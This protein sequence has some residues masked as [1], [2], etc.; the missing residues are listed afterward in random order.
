LSSAIGWHYVYSIYRED[1]PVISPSSVYRHYYSTLASLL[2]L[3]LNPPTAMNH[4]TRAI[5][6]QW[7]SKMHITRRHLHR[8][9]RAIQ[10]ASAHTQRIHGISRV[11][12]CRRL[13]RRPNNAR[14]NSVNT[15]TIWCLLLRKTAGESYDGAL[16]GGVVEKHGVG[17]VGC[18]R[19]AVY[20]AVAALHVFECV[21]GHGEHGDDVGVEGLFGYVEVDFGYVCAGFLHGGCCIISLD[22]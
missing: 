3:H 19:G 17:H 13:Q 2:T 7:T 22:W 10:R 21:F 12:L 11:V 16:R 20:D 8:H 5:T 1:V 9:S 14:R 6:S 4:L 18:D 15:N